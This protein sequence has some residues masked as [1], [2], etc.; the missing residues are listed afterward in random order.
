MHKQQAV[1]L[2]KLVGL[3]LPGEF[4]DGVLI[5]A[6]D[7]HYGF[8]PLWKPDF[9]TALSPEDRCHVNGMGARDGELAYATVCGRFDTPL[10]W[11]AVKHGGVWGAFVLSR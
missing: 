10:G 8:R 11:K 4:E 9:I 7:A 5:A 1:N 6:I 3:D 2:A